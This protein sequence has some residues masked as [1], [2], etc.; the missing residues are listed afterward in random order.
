MAG[1]YDERLALRGDLMEIFY[2]VSYFI[3]HVL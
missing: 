3:M 2:Q 1:V